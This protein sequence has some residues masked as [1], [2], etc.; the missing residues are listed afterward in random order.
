VGGGVGA[1]GG[2]RRTDAYHAAG[3]PI[4]REEYGLAREGRQMFGAH[5]C[6]NGQP[7]K[8]DCVA[9]GVRSS[10]ES[11]L[12]LSPAMPV[13]WEKVGTLPDRRITVRSSRPLLVL[14]EPSAVGY[15]L[16]P[17]RRRVEFRMK[18]SSDAT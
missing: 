18:R 13:S 14:R 5:S 1:S 7:Q 3:S 9:L 10:A 17:G 15:R 16:L 8:D 11:L 12:M 2:A 4:V 6:R